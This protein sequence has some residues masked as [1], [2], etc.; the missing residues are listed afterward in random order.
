MADEIPSQAEMGISED[1]KQ[2][3]RG[4]K[5][6]VVEE[7]GSEIEEVT[8]E[9]KERVIQ[10]NKNHD[11]VD[12]IGTSSQKATTEEANLNVEGYRTLKD[13][14][15]LDQNVE[16]T[17]NPQASFKEI[18]Q[19]IEKEM[20]GAQKDEAGETQ[21]DKSGYE[22]LSEQV[23]STFE[24][25]VG[26]NDK[27]SV[28]NP[29]LTVESLN[30]NVETVTDPCTKA[31]T[32]VK[33]STTNTIL[34]QEE[35][36][37]TNLKGVENKEA[38]NYSDLVAEEKGP[39]AIRP[40]EE[41]GN[42]KDEK[43][44]VMC[45]S[46]EDASF[47]TVAER[48]DTQNDEEAALDIGD[49]AEDKLEGSSL[50]LEKYTASQ[51]EDGPKVEEKTKEASS[52]ECEEK[53]QETTE[54]NKQEKYA[55]PVEDEM[56]KNNSSD[57]PFVKEEMHLQEVDNSD[58]FKLDPKIGV[59]NIV[60][61]STKEVINQAESYEKIVQADGSASER[62]K[63]FENYGKKPN[64]F[65]MA[66]KEGIQS[67]GEDLD[68][69]EASAG[70][71]RD[72]EGF[73][74]AV[75]EDN[76]S[77]TEP[78]EA[79]EHSKLASTEHGGS[80]E[81][82]L[83]QQNE[84]EKEKPGRP[85]KVI[86][87]EI[88]T[89]VSRENVEFENPEDSS[90]EKRKD[91][92]PTATYDIS[93]H[94]IPGQ[95]NLPLIDSNE[96]TES[97]EDE[98]PNNN[99]N[100]LHVRHSLVE[101]TG[102]VEGKRTDEQIH[103]SDGISVHEKKQLANASEAYKST[104]STI[105]DHT[106][107]EGTVRKEM[108]S[109][110][111]ENIKEL[112]T[113]HRLDSE[114][115]I[116]V[117][118]AELN[119]PEVTNNEEAIDTEIHRTTTKSN[120]TEE[121]LLE[122]D[123]TN[124]YSTVRTGDEAAKI[125]VESLKEAASKFSGED[126]KNNV[127]EEEAYDGHTIRGSGDVDKEK[128]EEAN[129]TIVTPKLIEKETTENYHDDEKETKMSREEYDSL[130]IIKEG[131][132]NDLS[133]KSIGEGPVQ[134]FED[135][136]KEAKKS[137]EEIFEELQTAKTG[138]SLAHEKI[139][140]V[141]S[142]G[143]IPDASLV[144]QE[145]G[146]WQEA[147]H[148]A[149][150]KDGDE[151]TFSVQGAEDNNDNN[152]LTEATKN[153]AKETQQGEEDSE[154]GLQINESGESI[155]VESPE[156]IL[157]TSLVK[158]KECLKGEGE[159]LDST[160][161]SESRDEKTSFIKVAEDN[162]KNNRSAE[163]TESSV[164][165][166]P[167]VEED[168]D[169]ILQNNEPGE[170][171]HEVES[172]GEILDTVKPVEDLQGDIDN[173]APA[174]ASKEKRDVDTSSVEAPEDNTD[175]NRLAEA[176]ENSAMATPEGEEISE[177]TLQKDEPGE[178]IARETNH[179]AE[180]PEN[181]PDHPLVKQEEGLQGECKKPAPTEAAIEKRDEDTSCVEVAGDNDNIDG[182][183][184]TI[185]N[186]IK[187]TPEG[188]EDSEK[189]LQ[190]DE[191][192]QNIVGVTN[193]NVVY[194]TVRTGNEAAKI[195]VESL[196]EAASKFSGEDETNN[197]IEEEAY[198][199][200]TIRG[201]GDI[202][203][204]K[205]EEAN[206]TFV[207]PK[208][209]AKETTENYHDDEKETKMSREE[210]D[211]LEIIKEG[212]VNDLSLKSIG[213]G[214]I[215]IFEDNNKEAKKS[216]EE[217]FEELQT[218]KTGESLAHEK[219]PDVESPGKIPDASLVKQEEG[220]WQEAEHLASA[221]ASAKDGDEE[222]FS[223][224]G[225]EDNNDNN[226]LTEATENSAKE[227]QQGEEDSEQ[228]L[229]INE[230][231]ESI[232]V[233][234]PENILHTSLVNQKECLKGEGEDLDSTEASESR[235]EETFLIK[236][237]EDNSK[238][239][240]SAETTES[241][242]KVIPEVEEDSDHVLQNNEP[243]ETNHEVESP[244]EILDTVKPAEG[245]QGDID[246]QAPAKASTEKRDVDTSSVEAPEDNTDNNRLAEATENSAK[247]TPE[248]EE[249]SEHALQKDE[250]G[251]SIARE[252]NHGAESPENCPDH[253]LVKQEEGLQG[254][255]KMP[256]PTEAAIEKRDEDTS[257]VEVAGDNDNI[258]GVAESIEKST[259]VTP[260]GGEDSEKVL[261]IDE[262][263]QNIVGVTNHNV[264]SLENNLDISL[265]K[266]EEGI[267]GED[268]NLAPTKASIQNTDE[269]T[270]PVKVDEG[271][272]NNNKQV[273]T[274]ENSVKVTPKGEED[275][276]QLLQKDD[277]QEN[278]VE[279]RNHEVK[280][281]EE[282]L[283]NS[284]V[285]QKEDLQGKGENLAP[286]EASI[287]NKD[288][289]SS[290]AI[291]A[292]HKD[293]TN[294]QDEARENSAKG[295]PKGEEDSEDVLQKDAVG[296]GIA[297]EAD[298]E[299]ESPEKTLN[300]PPV[301]QEEGLQGEDENPIPTEASIEKRDEETSSI[302]I[303][304][305][306][307]ENNRLAEPAENSAKVTAKGEEDLEQ[308]FQKDE[309]REKI[310]QLLDVMPE[311]MEAESSSEKTTCVKEE[312]II[313]NLE[314]TS[315]TEKKEE[316]K[317]IDDKKEKE[318]AVGKVLNTN[319]SEGT[320]QHVLQEIGS[321]KDQSP[322]FVEKETNKESS[323]TDQVQGTNLE[324][325]EQ[326]E[327]VD[328]IEET[329][330]RTLQDYAE[331]N[332]DFSALTIANVPEV[333]EE[334]IK[335]GTF[336]QEENIINDSYSASVT[337]VSDEPGLKEAEPENNEQVKSFDYKEI[338]KDQES[339]GSETIASST[340]PEKSNTEKPANE[341]LSSSVGEVSEKESLKEDE[342][343]ATKLKE[344]VKGTN[345]E[346]IEQIE[347]ID[348][349][350]ETKSETLQDSAEPNKDF[351]AL[352]KANVH[353][354][355]REEIKEETMRQEENIINDSYS[356]SITIVSE[357]GLKEAKPENNEQVKSFDNKEI[358]EE[359][360]ESRESE[361][362]SSSTNLEKSNTEKPANEDL[363]SSVGEVLAKESLKEDESDATKLKEEVKG[364][365][366]EFIEQIEAIDLTEGT[367]SGTL[368]DCVEPKLD[369]SA[370]T[371]A[372]VSEVSEEEIKEETLRQE[373]NIINDSY[374]ASVT[375]VNDE[376]GLKE[377]EPKNNEQVKSFDNK[378]ISKD[379]ESRGSKTVASST[380]PEKSNTEK[381][382]NEDLSSSVG[383]VSTK[384]SLKEDE[385]EAMKL[386]EEVK[387]KN[388]EF[389]DQ[390]E[391]IDLTEETKSKTLQDCVEPNK[392]FS[393]LT[394]ANVH[395]V[396]EEEIKEE[397]L[398]QEKNVINDSYSASVTIVSDEA[399][400]KEAEP[401]NNEQ[402]KSFDYKEISKDQ[403]SRGSETIA[404]STNPEKSNI[405]KPA[406]EDLSSSVG[407]VSA[408]E[409]L[410][411]D[412]SEAMKLK[413]EVQGTN[414]EFIEQIEAIDLTEETKSET[415][416]DCAEPNKDFSALTK[417]NVREVSEEEIKEETLR[418][419]ENII[420]DSYFASATVVSEEEGLKE[421]E[422]EKN[423]QV[424]SFDNKEI[425]EEDQESRE[426]ETVS[427]STN[428]EKS[429][430]EKPANEDL[431]SSVGE[432]SAKES[433]KE[434]ESDATKL[435]EEVKCTNLEFIE[436]IEAI[437]LTE[438]TKSGTLEDCVEPNK[439]F[440]AL[441]IA[442]VSEV[443]E[444]S[445][446]EIKEETLR[447]EE[448]IINDSYSPSITVV[449]D[450]AGLKEV[451]P[452]NKEQVKSFDNKEISKDQESRGSKTVASSTNPE[453]SNT[454]KPANEDLSS[455]VGEVS[456]KESLK[457]DESEAMKLKEEVKG[458][459][460]EFIDQIET[461]DLTEETKSETLQDYA[462]PNKDFSALTIG[463]VHEVS[464]EE[465][466][467]ENL[468][469]E[470][471]I[472]SDSYS[473]SITVAS[474]EEGL[475]EA[476]PENNEQV[477]SFD[478]KEISEEDQESRESETISSSTNP[479]Q[480][481]T[482][483]PANED[484]SSS[485]AE[486]SVK[487]SLKEDESDARKLK[488][489]V[490]GTNLEF[491]E[492]IEAIDLTEETK[493]GTLQDCVEP[494]KYFSASTIVNVSGVSDEA[495]L[496][497]AEPEN[498]EQVKSFDSEEISEEDQESRGSKTVASSTNPEK[499]NTEKP[500]N[501]D[502]SSSVGEV[503]TKERL[504]EDESEAMK[505]KEEVKGQNLEFIDQIETIDLTE[506]TKSETLQ[507]YAGPNKD[508][509]ALTIGN[510]HEVSEEEI[511]EE[512]LRQE[513]NII[514][515][516]YSASITVA[517]EEEGLKETE[518][519]NN[520]LVKSFDNKEISEE[521]QESRESETVS[522]SI[523]SEKQNTDRPSNE[524][525]S[526]S[527][528]EVSTKESLKEDRSDT[529]NL[530]EEIKGTN[531]EFIEQI[532]AI[533]LTEE[534]KSRALQDCVEP[535]KDFSALSIANVPKVY[536][537]EIKEETLRQEENIINDSCPVPVTVESEEADLREA[538]PE[539]I[540]QV[541]SSDN[542]E[543]SKE[544]QESR[545]SKTVASSTN[546]EKRNT[547]K[548]S[549]GDRSFGEV[550]A[551]ESLKEDGS[552]TTK[553]KEEIKG[554][555]LELIEQIEAIDLAEETKSRTLQD[556]AETNKEFSALTIAN[557]PEVFEEENKE[558]TS[559]QEENTINDSYSASVTAVSEEVGLKEAEPENNE[560]VQSS[561]NKEDSKD[562]QESRG[563]EIVASS[564][565]S[566]KSNTEKPFNEDCSSSVREVSVKE[567]LKEDESDA[568]KLREEVKG[569]NL[570]FIE[571]TE[572][573][574]LTEETKT[575]T[576]QDCA[577]P[578]KDFSALTIANVSE[579][580][581]EE[582]KEENIINDSYSTFVTVVREETSLKEAKPE[583]NEQ[584]KSSDNKENS[585]QDQESR[586]SEIVASS[587]NPK[588]SNTEKPANDDLSSS[589]GELSAKESLKEDES[590]ATKL[591]EEVKGTNLEFIEQIEALD[592]TK[593]TKSGTLQDCLESNKDF[594]ALTIA[595][596]PEVS[597]EEIK[598]E[599]LKQ[600]ENINDD[601]E[602]ASVTVVSE[603][604]SLKEA[605]LE[606]NEQVRSSDISSEEKGL[607]TIEIEGTSLESVNIDAK[608]KEYSNSKENMDKDILALVDEGGEKLEHQMEVKVPTRAI[609][610]EI[611]MTTG[612]TP[613]DSISKDGSQDSYIMLLK[614]HQPMT[615]AASKIVEETPIRDEITHENVKSPSSVQ[616]TDEK[617]TQKED[618]SI[619]SKD[620]TELLSSDDGKEGAI[621]EVQKHKDTELHMAPKLHNEKNSYDKE[622]EDISKSGETGELADQTEVCKVETLKEENPSHEAS[623]SVAVSTCKDN[624]KAILEQDD[625]VQN[626][627]G[628]LTG[629]VVEKGTADLEAGAG[630]HECEPTNSKDNKLLVEK[631]LESADLGQKLDFVSESVTKDQS[632]ETFPQ[633]NKDQTEENSNDVQDWNSE[634]VERQII[635]QVQHETERKMAMQ[636]KLEAEDHI[637]VSQYANETITNVIATEEVHEGVE[638][639]DGS[640][641]IKEHAIHGESDLKEIHTVSAGDEILEKVKDSGPEST[642][643]LMATDFNEQTATPNTGIEEDPTREA[644]APGTKAPEEE[645]IQ[646]EGSLKP[647]DED[648]AENMKGEIKVKVDDFH[649]KN[650]NATVV[651][652]ESSS[653]DA[654][655]DDKRVKDTSSDESLETIKTEP[656]PQVEEVG[657]K[658]PEKTSSSLV[659]Q[660]P[661]MD[662]K[663]VEKE[664]VTLN[665]PDADEVE[666]TR[667]V[668]SAVFQ[669]K[670]HS[671]EETDKTGQSLTVEKLD[672]DGTEEAI[673]E[674][675][676]T[677]SGSKYLGI[678]AVTQDEITADQT[679]PTGKL[680]EQFQTPSSEL[681]SLEQEHGPTIIVKETKAIKTREGEMLDDKKIDD[682]SATKTTE[683][684][685]LQKEEQLQT[686][687]S[688]L[689]SRE[690]GHGTT[691]AFEKTE[692][693]STREAETPDDK[694][695]NNSSAIK[696]TEETCL[697]QEE[698]REL[699]VSELGIE[700]N[701]DI[702]MDSS[703]K[704]HKEECCTSDGATKLGTEENKERKYSRTLSE[705]EK[706]GEL[707]RPIEEPSNLSFE[708][709]EKT[710]EPVLDVH[711]HEVLIS[712]E[713]QVQDEGIVKLMDV[714]TTVAEESFKDIKEEVDNSCDKTENETA[715][716]VTEESSSGE[717]QLRDMS[718]KD[719]ISHERSLE[720]IIMESS[721]LA[722][723]VASMK[724][725]ET[726]SNLPSQLPNMIS[727]NAKK[728]GETL[729]SPDAHEV[730]GT[731][732]TSDA[733]FESKYQSVKETIETG[734]SLKV[735]KLDAADIEEIKE[736]SETLS[737]PKALGV[738]AVNKDGIIADQ[739]LPTGTLGEQLQT[740]SSSVLSGEQEH[741]TTTTVER[742]EQ[743]SMK[744]VRTLSNES[745][746]DSSAAKTTEGTCFKKKE[747]REFEV[748][749]L[750]LESGKAIQRDSS[751]EVQKEE[752]STLDQASKL[753]PQGKEEIKYADSPSESEEIKELTRPIEEAF[754]DSS[755]AK[756]T[757]GTFFKKKEL[758]EFEVP[759][760]GLESGK[761]IQ[762]DSS[763]EVQKEENSTLDQASKLEPQE[764]EEIKY[765]DS[766]SES[767]EIKELTRPIEEA[768]N[769][770]FE[771]SEKVSD[772]VS[773]VQSHEVLTKSEDIS[774]KHLEAV[775][776]DLNTEE[777]QYKK[778]AEANQISKN[779]VSIEGVPEEKEVSKD[780]KSVSPGEET[781]IES[782]QG[783]ESQTEEYLVEETNKTFKATT[784][785]N[786]H[787]VFKSSETIDKG[788][789]S[790]SIEKKIPAEDR[791]VED[792]NAAESYPDEAKGK[793]VE[794]AAIKLELEHQS[795]ETNLM[796]GT[797][798]VITPREKEAGVE[799]SQKEGT[800]GFSEVNEI[801]RNIQQLGMTSYAAS[802]T[803]ISEADPCESTE[804]II[805]TGHEDVPPVLQH[806]IDEALQKVETEHTRPGK[807]TEIDAEGRGVKCQGEKRM[808]D[809]VEKITEESTSVESAKLP[810]SDLMQRSMKESWQVAKD[811][812]KERDPM[813]SK[814]E[815]QN[816]EAE[817]TQ[818]GEAKTDEEEG[819]EHKRT[820]PDSDA[821]VM[822]E[823]SKDID[824]KVAHKKSHN[825]LS[826]VGSKV[827]HSISKVRKAITGKSSHPK[828]LSPK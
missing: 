322:E 743:E 516:S 356:A 254:E 164:K 209:I 1:E 529:T 290:P 714:S 389:T 573:I 398:R 24:A 409:S 302:K 522:S 251:E 597:E 488:E 613:L 156:N 621:E 654:Q 675:S 268:D 47:S 574:D 426:S 643:Y 279:G 319:V 646:D 705:S 410:K 815:M 552:D 308:V 140:D 511:K 534:T 371:I 406:N 625:S 709:S 479:K 524:D 261:Q 324:L 257:C 307:D 727:E 665:E 807:A 607:A 631:N 3:Q 341:D 498:N 644:E 560:Q 813:L 507:D 466:K 810:L 147:E 413:E 724:L 139:P 513:E 424:K 107:T 362:V 144:K 670:Y 828:T 349:T 766:P 457:E 561:D 653:R 224:Q 622:D 281:L 632:D 333:S 235:D 788:S 739:T 237:A 21:V 706:T 606:N 355:S 591:K 586:R 444:V 824:V 258:D 619:K 452:E 206:A 491:I 321:V 585:K 715:E 364:T 51:Q 225:A 555:N 327:A 777:S 343:E 217:N 708:I 746:D 674:A 691:T 137:T 689:L 208:L 704:L 623:K 712:S 671:V 305:G 60:M 184:E 736:T 624:E 12:V 680:E 772:H 556:C 545:G 34:F 329:K 436:Q 339:R 293:D 541:K 699:K 630:S 178:S 427:S 227:T 54:L 816:E 249:I 747:L 583:N 16:V 589:V 676:G 485:V 713:E 126:E 730:E 328:L 185:E 70:E 246:N 195:R 244:G 799:I 6:E 157:H 520:E 454:E 22:E 165:V 234:S 519:K 245:L 304:E 331:P 288:E 55:T 38:E 226:R 740:L 467:E 579:V 358:S 657:S 475:K 169:H 557:V 361:T 817:T 372:N 285:N 571:Q 495:G 737:K 15:T 645:K 484:L 352:T 790:E 784:D 774:E 462:G 354:M 446:E 503:S 203:K 492:Q 37:E 755:A 716:L 767:E 8:E 80:P 463:N 673:K 642:E 19:S 418:Q 721:P 186:N 423:E 822:V 794:E 664:G 697:E 117:K 785:V 687:S 732:T 266:Q 240:R 656:C 550:L 535:N 342:S 200:H 533:D 429:N 669:S 814:A 620:L 582:I 470:E 363:S 180:S 692:G 323:K 600:E 299:L 269:D 435:K 168:S 42:K 438:E 596:V 781:T 411:E 33:S 283:D 450:E 395:E 576:L 101:E 29:D 78:I 512:T 173:Q 440:C 414:L 263:G 428:L 549:N 433:L 701:K 407:E 562:D 608:P 726:S 393:A 722:E 749:T 678:E 25:T 422:P 231:G 445:E 108:I 451:K 204:E 286:T 483:K 367:K 131:N 660:L 577:E 360:Q 276:E 94:E 380:N 590:D 655:I 764:K 581:E 666:E 626:F 509:S 213:E 505:L 627:E 447:Q 539:N 378:E 725:E 528:G 782:H 121:G 460:L 325:I 517:S 282:V 616:K 250:P 420:N 756:T 473:A 458:T 294:G 10:D 100:D 132:A 86:S 795:G 501:E 88:E 775:I 312:G 754:D 508:F 241:S 303:A 696:A 544:D 332:K 53:N 733:V 292:E 43:D 825:I 758:R 826:S 604:A 351:S 61:D 340:N 525:L 248:G 553:L 381:P 827:K 584:V 123:T 136:N 118:V 366:L 17:S 499:S 232:V 526:S 297:C 62:G 368:Q 595:K 710:F 805:S 521:D 751:N 50:T 474:E 75:T 386:K 90:K 201:S 196:E 135:N 510:V 741:E 309:P 679:L 731:E 99:A 271:N 233:E 26:Q 518:P 480:A 87:E 401:E 567:S 570:E 79:I 273:E 145:E 768:S 672:A 677:V 353:E 72:N 587:T 490:K 125:R 89:A 753:E 711:S 719:I 102:Q 298:H 637:N 383:E 821:P 44:N 272:D 605:E 65:S 629:V 532:E 750:G 181:Y 9:T 759:T 211:S 357:E 193:H 745:I 527:F 786:Q 441:T 431:S 482:E 296:E 68:R 77:K 442:N 569:T 255:C 4:E 172:P 602:S 205:I 690:Q 13:E 543:N 259:K 98:I 792:D 651:A 345:L 551:K 177:H 119:I 267:Q 455:S 71:K 215:Q 662:H 120:D 348:L 109:K 73:T 652:A 757:E 243:G 763:N 776:T 502:L 163:T 702:Q 32:I 530:K 538:E 14:S 265:V 146:L 594:N 36:G 783:D 97:A 252:T 688:T 638:K 154:Q 419:E 84:P 540:E 773:E 542:Q 425:S 700:I 253:P 5:F 214:P 399:G 636:S 500:A 601:F 603:E 127:I 405:E 284:L 615:A 554:T 489:E 634:F 575:R 316:T 216:T 336:R 515:D 67:K 314:E 681:L 179:G 105:S 563:S 64:A 649:D 93:G 760:L 130:E 270:F 819:D 85:L 497:E 291:V 514:T 114:E 684:M 58:I 523:N 262:P 223:V 148:L 668:S 404:S 728:E 230:S 57:T 52:A 277:P 23:I 143:K 735:E 197:V 48:P 315:E 481:N 91:D 18:P 317:A 415:L 797:T 188:G 478:N 456:T 113:V 155:V 74:A 31:E 375:A 162:G 171:N 318:A 110:T 187:V 166:I 311:E 238:N 158:Q 198:D 779:E 683:E 434:D 647:A 76:I 682:S 219:I 635:G 63:D 27:A 610:N 134:I 618:E 729:E 686:L 365:N 667:T 391:A 614:D 578:N 142:P 313:Q 81:L 191:P 640:E 346:F 128:I 461:I 559:N 218:A 408:K 811:S 39:E 306:N 229:Q 122:D 82:S 802:Q 808:V 806:P 202:D 56:Q 242:V 823:A 633:T 801:T 222:T 796:K 748:P 486:V 771:I 494:N 388:L 175:N 693:E 477:K 320:E 330:S 141:E 92:K 275:S 295:T 190:I 278:L 537:E 176:T 403:E 106:S 469:Q 103:K 663:N 698:P 493:S 744:E 761:A 192:G 115:K 96:K 770:N 334:E 789:A 778:P 566:E 379:Q 174:E 394:I 787:E 95:K 40:S 385:S 565:N 609:D 66:C 421:A 738:E 194:S 337:I 28:H 260:E 159:D 506:E 548:P 648:T 220:L 161:A 659:S 439:D 359:D 723:E 199:G 599:T 370:L 182:V 382:A 417:A 695:I 183:A 598:E 650:D 264:D 449:N 133:L 468:R 207:T 335:E 112:E 471:N 160:E 504:K 289:D 138:E 221:E 35:L 369:F 124:V 448:N 453:K 390:I 2:P 30:T 734:Q 20:K 685:C 338:S 443:S 572:A 546:Q 152:R 717:A 344:E 580:Y 430:T 812:T 377:V 793:N 639:V 46:I 432:V 373:E 387:G 809:S 228:G 59:E 49:G 69:A 476:E 459:N 104:E 531:L 592:L 588:K 791:T 236:E 818:F 472:I 397:T 384:E 153:S 798:D 412:E 558:E 820:D 149:S 694:N 628:S 465:I 310:E 400:L 769:H 804:A 11:T 274:T 376:A 780:S 568:T 151:D 212:N 661:N 611:E 742:A 752:N 402:V 765:A 720:T 416:Q 496:K 301:K 564:T 547:E 326:I 617:S 189:V 116:E 703:N 45:D 350:E 239:N 167:E 707:T 247:A 593:E 347:A 396:S 83:L 641:S 280:S 536:E 437:D 287:E 762:R 803:R 170:T 392:D 658:K 256:A 150:A 111:S 612:E 210:D 129:A 800:T 464:E 487:E 718:T 300:T 374:S 7:T 41:I